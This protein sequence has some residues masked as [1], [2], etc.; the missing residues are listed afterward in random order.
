FTWP[1]GLDTSNWGFGFAA[2]NGGSPMDV[3]IDD[4]TVDYSYEQIP[5][6]GALALLGLGGLSMRRRRASPRTP[7]PGDTSPPRPC[8]PRPATGGRRRLSRP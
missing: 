6:P 1:G 3:I 2:R 4:F 5:A 7:P 8:S